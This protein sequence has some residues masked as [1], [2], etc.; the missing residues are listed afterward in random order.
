M[1]GRISD[2]VIEQV[3]HANDV[4][5]VIGAYFPLKK[6]GANFRALCPFHK[7]KTPSFNVTPSKQIWHCF[8]C[9][10]GGD[11]FKFV[12][13]Y[14]S[15]DFLA[16]VR[17]LAERAGIKVEEETSAGMA[18]RGEKE[19]LFKLHDEAAAFFQ[20]NLRTADVAKRYLEKRQIS[21]E[22]ARKWRI[23]YA[24]DAWDGLIQWAHGKKYK[25]ALL[26]TA[27]LALARDGGGLY[28]RFR[29][30]LMFSICDESGRVVGF[31]GR[32]LTDAKDQPK[33]VNSPETPIFQKGRVLFALDKAKRSIIEDK[34]AVLCEGQIDTIACHEAGITNVVA[35][36]GTAL[37][38]QHARILKRYAEEVV[39]MY[40]A[41]E[42]G[43]N[44]IVRSA[45]PLWEAGMAMRAA[46]IP[47]G[48]DPD[49]F[50]KAEG[51]EKL[52]A[53][54]TGGESF[55]AYLLKRLSKQHNPAT[56]RGKLQIVRQMAEWLARIPSPVLLAT[57]AQQTAQ[58][59]D[60]PE[61]AIRQELRKLQQSRQSA[62]AHRHAMEMEDEIVEMTPNMPEETLLLQLMLTDM[63][64]VDLALEKLDPVW[65]TTSVAGAV[66]GRV[67]KLHAVGKWDGPHTLMNA[68]ADEAEGR[69]VSELAVT[70][71]P[72]AALQA[73]TGDCLVKLERVYVKGQ[74]HG[75]RKQL[76]QADLP[77]AER[78]QLQRQ[79]L[80]LELKLRH[81]V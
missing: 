10:V 80:D 34:Y 39:L 41:D 5:D 78:A 57:Y 47:A 64:L 61:D 25:P 73:M 52:R 6:A 22:V 32:I 53:L 54:I 71:V 15:L 42:A 70:P 13:M 1:P 2:Q 65:L 45:E 75:L 24:V 44:A 76:G 20:E 9:G 27:G 36:Q 66:I 60:V 11:V 43:Q 17:R 72:G 48:H 67:L 16:A 33:Y 77:A 55:F 49:S 68:P 46:V 26:A 19:M 62:A 29:G 28:D 4:V 50:I 81:S 74:L 21:L 69:L 40:D 56:E 31:S 58:R 8:G 30:R 35:P 63:R 7:E 3:R 12:M 79:I 37:T 14:E 38:E 59:L 23:G 18:D 51:G